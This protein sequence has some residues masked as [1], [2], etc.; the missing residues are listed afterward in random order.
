[1]PFIAR[2]PGRRLS[3]V[4]RLVDGACSRV[5]DGRRHSELFRPAA[6]E[7]CRPPKRRPECSTRSSATGGAP[8]D[9]AGAATETNHARRARRRSVSQGSRSASASGG[10][11]SGRSVNSALHAPI[12]G[13][14]ASFERVER[15]RLQPVAQHG[16]LPPRELLHRRNQPQYEAVRRLH[17][18]TRPARAGCAVG[19]RCAHRGRV[20]LAR[21]AG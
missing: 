4:R 7:W 9:R 17:R 18:R 10:S 2:F 6:A 14:P 3:T 20:V 12:G 1:M 8:C 19:R 11:D 13:R 5:R 21:A 15:R 16:L